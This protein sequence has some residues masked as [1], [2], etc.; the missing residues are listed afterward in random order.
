M[1]QPGTNIMMH[2]NAHPNSVQTPPPVAALEDT[3]TDVDAA[4]VDAA[5]VDEADD[6]AALLLLF[7]VELDETPVDDDVTKP[8]LLEAI[9]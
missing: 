5:E 2:M 7:D 8:E 3:E 4:E 6:E 9:P 1:Q